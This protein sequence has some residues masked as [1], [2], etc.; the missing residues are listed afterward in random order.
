MAPENI[1]MWFWFHP[2]DVD[3]SLG[4]PV[5]RK[6]RR[7]LSIHATPTVKRLYRSGRQVMEAVLPRRIG[8]MR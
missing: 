4:T 3:L 6:Q 7:L 5:E 2:S 8:L 1:A